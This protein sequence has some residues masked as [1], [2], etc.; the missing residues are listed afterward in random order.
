MLYHG[1][2]R[3][4]YLLKVSEGICKGKLEDG[5]YGSKEGC[6]NIKENSD[7]ATIKDSKEVAWTGWES[8]HSQSLF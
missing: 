2:G 5:N 4:M 7:F 8:G 6:S 3:N 1:S